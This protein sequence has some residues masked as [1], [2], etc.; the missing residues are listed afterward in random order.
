M[1]VHAANV[2]LDHSE[3]PHVAAACRISEFELGLLFA[4][5]YGDDKR[6]AIPQLSPGASGFSVPREVVIWGHLVY[7]MLTR[8]ELTPPSLLEWA[9]RAARG[10]APPGPPLLW[11]LLARIFLPPP[12]VRAARRRRRLGRAAARP[13]PATR[14]SSG[15]AHTRPRAAPHARQG[16]GCGASSV[17]KPLR[18][19]IV[20]P[21]SAWGRLSL[22]VPQTVIVCTRG[23]N[24]VHSGP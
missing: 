16:A 9:R 22:N 17:G 12:D 5:A 15:W 11:H 24:R 4:P 21:R 20:A 8:A 7:E 2:M 1:H 14:A 23:C 18:R 19:R 13:Q 3:G 6:L 10:A